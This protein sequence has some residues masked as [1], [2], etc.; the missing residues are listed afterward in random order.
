MRDAGHVV[1]GAVEEPA[2]GRAPAVDERELVEGAFAGIVVVVGIEDQV[3]GTV[4][5]ELLEG[6][7][8]GAFAVVVADA[9]AVAAA[10]A[11]EVAAGIDLV[12][13][14]VVAGKDKAIRRD[15]EWAMGYLT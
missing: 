15:N 10:D 3:A 4:Q 9:F 12:D 11:S 14:F 7:A 2:V 6:P 1:L 8:A 5:D 13:R